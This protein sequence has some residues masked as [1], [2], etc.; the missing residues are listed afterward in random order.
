MGT[1][2]WELVLHSVRLGSFRLVSFA[3]DRPLG[4]SRLGSLAWELLLGIE[5]SRLKLFARDR[6]LGIVR[7]GFVAWN[8][9][10][11]IVRFGTCVCDVSL[12]IFRLGTFVLDLEH[13]HPTPHP[14]PP[15]ARHLSLGFFRWSSSA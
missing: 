4:S 14:P 10:H 6:S 9:S 13:V 11:G 12:G 15:F 8:L 2:A 5:S 7:L 3:S 1:F